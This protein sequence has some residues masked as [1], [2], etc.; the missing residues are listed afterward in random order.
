MNDAIVCLDH[1][2]EEGGQFFTAQ[3]FPEGFMCDYCGK[4]V[5]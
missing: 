3:F 1:A 4:V 2:L 5:K